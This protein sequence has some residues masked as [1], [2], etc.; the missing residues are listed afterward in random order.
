MVPTG[1]Y[2]KEVENPRLQWGRVVYCGF[3][4]V[5]GGR[6]T[7]VPTPVTRPLVGARPTLED[8]STGPDP[9]R[10]S[11]RVPRR[12]YRI[13]T[14]ALPF[15]GRLDSDGSSP[16]VHQSS[17]TRTQVQVRP[18]TAKGQTLY[19]RRFRRRTTPL[20]STWSPTSGWHSCPV[21]E[22]FLNRKRKEEKGRM[23]GEGTPER[24]Q[25]GIVEVFVF[26]NR[27]P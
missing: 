6:A 26:K 15:P 9:H 22:P 1:L 14:Q 13:L 12:G 18:A 16:P 23:V 17:G 21:P 10:L 24:I 7:P 5:T 11:T 4:L 19:R 27:R 3:Q 2:S 20:F 8:G 25:G